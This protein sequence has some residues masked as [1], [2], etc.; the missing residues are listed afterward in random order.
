[1]ASGVALAAT[2]FVWRLR[3]DGRRLGALALVLPVAALGLLET[4]IE[5]VEVPA[6]TRIDV[7]GG[8]QVP[9]ALVALWARLS[10]YATASSQRSCA[11]RSRRAERP[12]RGRPLARAPAGA[13][14]LSDR[15]AQALGIIVPQLTRQYLNLI[16]SG[17]L[18]RRRL[19]RDLPD[20]SRRVL[21]PARREN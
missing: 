13:V 1:M 9:P 12:T 3:I 2:P 7:A 4:G 20:L 19:S 16:K 6:L 8:L 21:N 14:T 15:P 5:R 11:A 18:G 17:T 10:I